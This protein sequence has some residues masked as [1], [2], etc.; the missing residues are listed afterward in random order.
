MIFA[1]THPRTIRQH[2]VIYTIERFIENTQN[3]SQY[4]AE[5]V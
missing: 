5:S 2:H 3:E 4:I 1:F